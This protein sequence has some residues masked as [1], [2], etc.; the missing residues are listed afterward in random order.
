M[1]EGGITSGPLLELATEEAAAFSRATLLPS[2]PICMS[3]TQFTRSLGG[4]PGGD[5]AGAAGAE[6]A[7]RVRALRADRRDAGG[8]RQVVVWPRDAGGVEGRHRRAGG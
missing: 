8:A 3:G 7:G 6:A 5:P 1:V 4:W 2:Y